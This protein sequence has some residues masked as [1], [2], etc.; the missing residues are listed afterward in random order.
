MTTMTYEMIQQALE[1]TPED[2]RATLFGERPHGSKWGRDFTEEDWATLLGAWSELTP[3]EEVRMGDCRYF[4]CRIADTFPKATLGA[5]AFDE[6]TPERQREVRKV[7]GPHGP[8]LQIANY[9]RASRVVDATLVLGP[10]E[11]PHGTKLVVFT[12]HPGD[13]LAPGVELS[14]KTAV[15]LVEPPL[16]LEPGDS[17]QRTALIAEIGS[18]DN[19]LADFEGIIAALRDGCSL[20]VN[21]LQRLEAYELDPDLMSSLKEYHRLI[22]QLVER[23]ADRLDEIRG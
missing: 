9:L 2:H 17:E 21:E 11:T 18:L 19:Q 20:T 16:R 23:T 15:K 8:E 12:I 5:V 6:L 4:G 14:G 3:P 22:G 13:P 1:D 7:D 10:H